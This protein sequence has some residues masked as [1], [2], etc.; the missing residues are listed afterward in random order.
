M[1]KTWHLQSLS[2]SVFKAAS[3]NLWELGG[4]LDCRNSAKLSWFL[5]LF[6]V[7]VV[8]LTVTIYYSE[9]IQSKIHTGNGTWS[10]VEMRGSLGTT[11]YKLSKVLS[12][13]RLPLLLNSERIP[14]LY[15][16]KTISVWA[17]Y[18]WWN[19]LRI[20]VQSSLP[21]F[22]F[23]FFFLLFRATLM[24]Y[25]GSQA[26]GLIRAVAAGLPHSHSNHRS[27]PGLWPTPQVTATPDP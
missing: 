4:A 14:T 1:L 19:L 18:A 23:S 17:C 22:S 26:R 6:V 13:G 15:I 16:F 12:L 11:S 21:G 9:R 3:G 2:W 25:G 27:E 7:V 10:G 24:A 20:W 5:L 8:V